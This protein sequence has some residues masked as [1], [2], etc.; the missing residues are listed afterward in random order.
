[1]VC[2]QAPNDIEASTCKMI[3]WFDTNYHYIVSEFITNQN[4]ELHHDDLFKSTKP[5]LENNYRAKP[6]ILGRL[7]FLWLAKCK[8]ESFNKLL[9]LEK[10][11]PVYTEIFEQLSS[12]G[13]ECVQVDDPILVLDLPPEW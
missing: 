5:V 9:L 6:V 7:S 2:G 1:M 10:L 4:F 3:K 8:G 13:V 11:F 12:L